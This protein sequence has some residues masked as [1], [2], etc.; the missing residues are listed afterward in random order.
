LEKQNGGL[1]WLAQSKIK[2]KKKRARKNEAF[3]KQSGEG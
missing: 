2:R 1:G 3:R